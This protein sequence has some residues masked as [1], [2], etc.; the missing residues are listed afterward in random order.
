MLSS[1]TNQTAKISFAL[2]QDANISPIILNCFR[3]ENV[4]RTTKKQYVV[5]QRNQTYIHLSHHRYCS[6]TLAKPVV[7]CRFISPPPPPKHL[8]DTLVLNVCRYQ[9]CIRH[10]SMSPCK[11]LNSHTCKQRN[12]SRQSCSRKKFKHSR[13][14]PLPSLTREATCFPNRQIM[15]RMDRIIN[16]PTGGTK[17][18]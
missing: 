12:P 3:N 16:L 7:K 11:Q 15:A 8:N 4:F 10:M 6:K 14:Q 2:K 9:S 5:Q 18:R 17:N 1:Y 13:I